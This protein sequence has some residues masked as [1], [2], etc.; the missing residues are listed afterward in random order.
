MEFVSILLGI[1]VGF[2][3]VLLN[4][5]IK[6]AATSSDVYL[7]SLLSKHFLIGFSIGIISVITMFSFYFNASKMNLAQALILMASSS[8]IFSVIY[9][10]SIQKKT[11]PTIEWIIFFTL[12]VLYGYKFIRSA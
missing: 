12:I 3:N 2:L 10:S 11:I 1:L 8:V 9:T 6:G 4:V 5:F 7:Q